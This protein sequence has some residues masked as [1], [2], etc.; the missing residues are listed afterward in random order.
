MKGIDLK[1]FLPNHNWDVR[2]TFARRNEFTD[3]CCP[4]KFVHLLFNLEL[5]R[6]RSYYSYVLVLPGA[7][8]ALLLPVMFLLPVGRPEKFNLGE[9]RVIFDRS[10]VHP[11]AAFIIL[12]DYIVILISIISGS[13]ACH[14]K[15]WSQHSVEN[16]YFHL[17]Y[18]Y[19]VK[20]VKNPLLFLHQCAFKM[21]RPRVHT[22]SNELDLLHI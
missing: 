6:R 3:P 22:T 18:P 12:S 13:K 7:T 5:E 8:M 21:H 4:N 19:K 10:K 9:R 1:Y 14:F 2:N 20:I 15:V 17:I 16:L 11:N